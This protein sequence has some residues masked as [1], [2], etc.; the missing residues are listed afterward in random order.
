M[1]GNK[2]CSCDLKNEE[3]RL[4]KFGTCDA[5]WQRIGLAN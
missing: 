2:D 3:F 4:V 5:A 1:V